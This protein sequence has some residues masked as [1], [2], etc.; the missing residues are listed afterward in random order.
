MIPFLIHFLIVLLIVG[1]LFYCL[2]LIPGL[3]PIV[4]QVAGVVMV[5]VVLLWLLSNLGGWG[6]GGHW[7]GRAIEHAPRALAGNF[8]AAHQV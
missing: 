2:S 5:L 8:V 4:R 6:G 3:P 7:L 1:L